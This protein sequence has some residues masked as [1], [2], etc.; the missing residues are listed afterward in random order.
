MAGQRIIVAD[1]P[2]RNIKNTTCDLLV[3]GGGIDSELPEIL[4]KL[5]ARKIVV[6]PSVRRI[7]EASIMQ[8]ADSLGVECHSIRES[9]PYRYITE[10]P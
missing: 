2:P 3:I 5:K 1:C 7:R 6:H 4:M 9:G 10:L 8:Q